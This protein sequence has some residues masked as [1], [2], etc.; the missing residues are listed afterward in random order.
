MEAWRV[1]AI[2]KRRKEDLFV[3]SLEQV[4]WKHRSQQKVRTQSMIWLHA[5]V[6]MLCYLGSD[7]IRP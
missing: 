6:R 7:Q 4:S 5:R 1:Q 2:N 3:K